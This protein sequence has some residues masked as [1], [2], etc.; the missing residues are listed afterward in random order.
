MSDNLPRSRRFRDLVTAPEAF[1][2]STRDHEYRVSVYQNA[3]KGPES[4]ENRQRESEVDTTQDLEYASGLSHR[5]PSGVFRLSPD[6][7]LRPSRL[8]QDLRPNR[9]FRSI[10]AFAVKI[11]A[12]LHPYSSG[13]IQ[14]RKWALSIIGW[15]LRVFS[16]SLQTEGRYPMR[17]PELKASD[18]VRYQSL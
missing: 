4:S 1:D 7:H 3:P 8:L 16:C 9:K 18:F 15:T 6:V 10:S 11:I 2:F 17:S 13:A 12:S 5:S 14:D